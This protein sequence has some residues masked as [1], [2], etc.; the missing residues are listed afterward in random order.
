VSVDNLPAVC[1][2]EFAFEV[3]GKKSALLFDA[4]VMV[5]YLVNY[6]NELSFAKI[7]SGPK[8]IAINSIPK[9]ASE[10]SAWD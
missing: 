9:Q 7:P 8:P 10:A 2:F 4:G 5:H 3:I 1:G 6:F